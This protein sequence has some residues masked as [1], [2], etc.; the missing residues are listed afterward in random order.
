MSIMRFKLSSFHARN[1]AAEVF[2][3]HLCV[4]VFHN[5]STELKYTEQIIKLHNSPLC[6]KER[7]QTLG[8]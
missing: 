8:S 3:L 7:I 2:I 5:G 6:D 1:V 4:G